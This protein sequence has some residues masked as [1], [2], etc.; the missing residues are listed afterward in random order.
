MLTERD[1]AGIEGKVTLDIPGD[2]SMGKVRFRM[3]GQV[4]E[5]PAISEDGSQLTRNT[6]VYVV[7]MQDGVAR[8]VTL[9]ELSKPV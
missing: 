9:D 1:Y 6:V 2:G 4:V 7:T 5:M 8:V 3:R